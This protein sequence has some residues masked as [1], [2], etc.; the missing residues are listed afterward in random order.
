MSGGRVRD[1]LLGSYELGLDPPKPSER[2]LFLRGVHAQAHVAD[3]APGGMLDGRPLAAWCCE[4][5]AGGVAPDLHVAGV[6]YWVSW[7]CGKV[8]AFSRVFRV[9]EQ[10][11]GSR[12]SIEFW[13]AIGAPNR[14]LLEMRLASRAGVA[15][16]AIERWPTFLD[17]A[18]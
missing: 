3:P 11:D 1:R 9:V 2:S 4:R 13:R 12:R 18:Q 5:A 14:R 16:S 10:P 17:E 6:T 7:S 8:R 15:V